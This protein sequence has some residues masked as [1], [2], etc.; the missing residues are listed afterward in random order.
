MRLALL[1]WWRRYLLVSSSWG[2]TCPCLSSPTPSHFPLCPWGGGLKEDLEVKVPR[3]V[4]MF[5]HALHPPHREI[6]QAFPVG[7]NLRPT[8]W[9]RSME[10]L[11]RA[12]VSLPMYFITCSY[13][14]P[15]S[16]TK[17]LC[18]GCLVPPRDTGEWRGVVCWTDGITFRCMSYI[19]E[20]LW[21]LRTC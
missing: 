11:P 17:G 18:R 9:K 3:L 2:F 7:E 12:L 21:L 5:T 13:Q 19:K 10:S 14:K 4:S 15:A 20:F 1:T 6:P 16:V 8:L